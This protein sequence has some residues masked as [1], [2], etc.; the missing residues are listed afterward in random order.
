MAGDAALET[1]HAGPLGKAA[2]VKRTLPAVGSLEDLVLL[3]VPGQ[4]FESAGAS[5][6]L[7][8]GLGC[9]QEDEVAVA[10]PVAV[11][12]GRQMLVDSA[13]D[14]P[15][16]CLR[17]RRAAIRPDDVPEAEFREGL[18]TRRRGCRRATLRLAGLAAWA[19]GGEG[20]DEDRRGPG[21]SPRLT[22]V[23]WAALLAFAGTWL[24]ACS[25]SAVIVRLGFTP[26]FA[27]MMEPSTT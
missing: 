1:P 13:K 6:R 23:A 27:G 4:P 19:G 20:Q 10:A 15:R 2:G 17:I 22:L 18:R 24:M 7:V 5:G 21:T 3:G 26:R 9:P 16:Q 14:P 12:S 8:L 11:D 25:A